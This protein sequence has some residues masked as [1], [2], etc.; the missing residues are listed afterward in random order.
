MFAVGWWLDKTHAFRATVNA[1]GALII[2]L[3]V[4]FALALQLLPYGARTLAV[5]TALCSALGC[6]V[7]LELVHGVMCATSTPAELPVTLR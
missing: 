6:L 5:V 4:G 7:G 2:T 1:C 3:M